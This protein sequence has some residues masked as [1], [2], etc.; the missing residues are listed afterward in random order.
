MT[1]EALIGDDIPPMAR[2]FLPATPMYNRAFDLRVA[3]H[4]LVGPSWRIDW[5]IGGRVLCT[6]QPSV[7]GYMLQRKMAGDR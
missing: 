4:P 6:H 7:K 1:T 3:S 5:Y 2:R